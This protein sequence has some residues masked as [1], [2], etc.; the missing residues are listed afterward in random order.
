MT[1]HEPTA[2][3]QAPEPYAVVE[4]FLDGEAID[5]RRLRAALD[6]PSVR[7]HLVDL[8][9]LREGVR[10]ITPGA[11][12]GSRAQ[13]RSATLRWLAAAAAVFMAL[14][15]GY[16]TGQRTVAA[17][18]GPGGGETIVAVE[19]APAAPQPTQVI[20]LQPGVNWTDGPARK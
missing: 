18:S 19:S 10:A 13:T 6:E 7:D 4:A 5:P 11:W 14:S 12:I 16:Y 1:E 8:L 20:K 15:A 17:A 2:P 9:V 3:E